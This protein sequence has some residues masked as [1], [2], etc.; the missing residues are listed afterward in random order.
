MDSSSVRRKNREHM[1]SMFNAGSSFAFLFM[2]PRYSFRETPSSHSLTLITLECF[3]SL[4]CSMNTI[5]PS[6]CVRLLSPSR[7]AHLLAPLSLSSLRLNRRLMQA[8]SLD[9]TCCS[10]PRLSL[11]LSLTLTRRAYPASSHDRELAITVSADCVSEIARQGGRRAPGKR[12]TRGSSGRCAWRQ[13]VRQKEAQKG[14]SF[15]T[16]RMR[17]KKRRL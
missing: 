4:I 13:D 5:F 15:R 2:E 10:V 12:E 9:S 6:I 3:S 8:C 7:L 17:E 16:K 11:S 14:L 1:L